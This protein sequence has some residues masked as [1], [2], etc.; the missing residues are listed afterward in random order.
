MQTIFATHWHHLPISEVL[1]LLETNAD[2][3]LFTWALNKGTGE[4]EARTIAVNVFIMGEL[5]Y[6]FNCQ[7]LTRSMFEPGLFT[8]PW[9]LGG[10]VLMA[11]FQLLFTYL[12]LMNRMFHSAPLNLEVWGLILGIGAI[13]YCVVE[14]EKW[15]WLRFK[16]VK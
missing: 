10:V 12:P 8:N 2:F 9:L 14:F 6:L 3:G 15:L 7:S 1:D 13:I 5:F 4:R 11:A 16:K